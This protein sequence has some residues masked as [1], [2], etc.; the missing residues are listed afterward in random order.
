[1]LIYFIFKLDS[2]FERIACGKTEDQLLMTELARQ[3]FK[4]IKRPVNRRTS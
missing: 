3:I 1:M 2:A 4:S